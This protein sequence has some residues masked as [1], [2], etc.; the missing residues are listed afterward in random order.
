[1]FPGRG[2]VPV[3]RSAARPSASRVDPPCRLPRP[4]W[5]FG[6]VDELLSARLEHRE[7]CLLFFGHRE[8]LAAL[9]SVGR[10]I[11]VVREP[12]PDLS[13]LRTERG[14][15]RLDASKLDL[16]VGTRVYRSLI[17]IATSCHTAIVRRAAARE[18]TRTRVFP[19]ARSRHT[20]G[21][22]MYEPEDRHREVGVE[23]EE[24]FDLPI[25][26]PEEVVRSEDTEEEK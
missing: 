13:D 19:E 4:S 5:L 14:D 10:I 18:T 3:P 12:F 21:M 16:T 2:P 9:G 15:R 24:F 22:T 25:L 26:D 1:M 7:D 6:A 23:I 8:N 17:G 20:G 11:P